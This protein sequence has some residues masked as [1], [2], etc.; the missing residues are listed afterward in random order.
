MKVIGL[1][2]PASVRIRFDAYELDVLVDVLREQRADATRDAADTYAT[3]PPTQTRPI[4]DRHDRLRAVEGLLMQLEEQ[5]PDNRPGAVLV[6]ETDL[7]CDVARDGAREALRRLQ[8]AHERY[9][10]D[11]ASPQARDALVNATKTAK[12]WVVTLTAVDQVDHGWD[13]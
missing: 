8:E 7:M 6:G 13:A 4:D 10:D 11:G 9:T 12:A 3:T 2:A 5:P 1:G